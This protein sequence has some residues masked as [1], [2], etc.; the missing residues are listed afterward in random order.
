MK[1]LLVGLI[2]LL[3]VIVIFTVYLNAG[4]GDYGESDYS[5]FFVFLIVV[6]AL[7]VSIFVV[8]VIA[9]Y[10]TKLRGAIYPLEKFTK[11]DL[12]SHS[13]VYSHSHTTKYRYKS[14]KNK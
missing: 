8:A 6:V 14:S 5:S 11:L 1:T 13:D 2:I 4:N 3:A 10:K 7:G 12:T 9:S